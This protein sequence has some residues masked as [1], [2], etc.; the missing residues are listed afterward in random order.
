MGTPDDEKRKLA[1]AMEEQVKG[2]MA[3]AS[4]I[5]PETRQGGRILEVSNLQIFPVSTDRTGY[6]GGARYLIQFEDFQFP[7]YV[8]GY[9]TADENGAPVII[10][11]IFTDSERKFWLNLMDAMFIPSNS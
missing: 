11:M 2:K 1:K 7:F 4:Y 8:Y 6:S 9:S 5:N 10:A 3:G